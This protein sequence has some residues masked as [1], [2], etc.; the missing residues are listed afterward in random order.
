MRT[1][2]AAKLATLAMAA[3]LLAGT[4][5]PARAEVIEE[6]VAWV[7][8]DIITKSEVEE[9]E[10][11]L[12]AALYREY[13]GAELDQQVATAREQLLGQLID[14]KILVHRAARMYDLDAVG[15][16]LVDQLMTD[17]NIP[18]LE[19]LEELL[20]QE[21]L[22][23]DE[24]KRRLTAN[25]AP[26]YVIQLEVRRRIA[27]SDTEIEQYYN[28]NLEVFTEPANVTFREIVIL[29]DDSNREE[30]R[31]LA[32][33]VLNKATAPDADFEALVTEFSQAGTKAE[34]GK[35]GPLVPSDL[36]DE[37]AAAV[38]DTP[39]GEV[40]SL[41]DMPYGFHIV[42]IEERT[43]AVQ[44]PLEEVADQIRAFLENNIYY[45]KLAEFM[46]KARGEADWQVAKKYS[47][48]MPEG[49]LEP[50]NIR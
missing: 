2:T 20:V 23:L 29:A 42:K 11:N 25:V 36:N 26:D 48:R 45:Q 22:T 38:L 14:R 3:A 17:Q 43:E 10:Q 47:S 41:L 27:V 49:S 16:D 8:G 19:T 9:E 12:L 13:T 44:K 5:T 4:A 7:D 6:I 28:D 33:D 31:T 35:L 18:D 1:T 39:V 34:G 32:L 50:S 46:D 15:D 40:G 24:L 21:G 37:L 30:R